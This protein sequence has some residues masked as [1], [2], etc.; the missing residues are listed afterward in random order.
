MGRQKCSQC[1]RL[2][3]I[4]SDGKEFCAI[5]YVDNEGKGCLH[6][7][8]RL[9]KLEGKWLGDKSILIEIKKQFPELVDEFK[10]VFDKEKI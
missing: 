1:N 6:E 7:D 2:S 10:D 5:H 8:L 3:V 9:A 4:K